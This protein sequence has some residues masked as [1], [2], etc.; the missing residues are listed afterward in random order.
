M[1]VACRLVGLSAL[2]AHYAGI[3]V[4]AQLDLRKPAARLA[5]PGEDY[6][7]VILRTGGALR[8]ASIRA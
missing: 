6:S 4:G 7:A 2:G 1:L 3:G 5:G 8:T